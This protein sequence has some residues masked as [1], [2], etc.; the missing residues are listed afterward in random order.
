MH[1]LAD[2][3]TAHLTHDTVAVTLA[4]CLHRVGNVAY[5]LP[6]LGGGDALVERSLGHR[7]QVKHLRINLA[8][9]KRVA[10]VGIVAVEFRHTVC[11]DDVPFAQHIVGWETVNHSLVDLYA[12]SSGETVI[13]KASGLTPVVE[14]KLTCY[15]I[16]L[17]RGDTRT[18]S[19]GNLAKC[20]AEQISCCTYQFDFFRCLEINHLLMYICLLYDLKSGIAC[21]TAL[22]AAVL[23][24][25]IVVAH[26]Q[27]TLYDAECVKYDTHEN[28]QRCSA[29]E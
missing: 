29:E 3:V 4:I 27:M 23:H 1:A 10:H 17:Q 16:E 26:Q 11:A 14:D 15:G 19:L 28:Q 20:P 22:D 13:P 9:C 6:R 5:T 21:S 7:E 25:S 18:D 12:E 24:Q 2:A 8:D